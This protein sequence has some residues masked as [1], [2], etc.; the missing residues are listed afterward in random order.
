MTTILSSTM[1]KKTFTS[2]KVMLSIT[3]GIFFLLVFATVVSAHGYVESPASRAYLCKQNL[4]TNCGQV[5]Y[6]PQSVEGKGNFPVGGPEDGKITGGGIFAQLYDQTTDRWTKLDMETGSQTFT[7]TLTAP[8]ATKE[9]KYYIT[10]QDW[11]PNTPIKRSDLELFCSYSDNG[12]VPEKTVSHNCSVPVDHTGYHV[13]LG[14]WEIADT[15]NAF[16]QA[17]D[18]NLRKPGSEAGPVIDTEAP[19]IPTNVKA[20][21]VTRESLVLNWNPSK[22]NVAVTNYDIYQN[23]VKIASV[24][25]TSISY[26]VSGLNPGTA[27]TYKLKAIDAAGNSSA[28][29]TEITVR[30][31]S[32]TVPDTTAPTAPSHL[33]AHTIA[34]TSVTLMWS[35]ST[36]NVAV[37]AYDIYQGTTRI[38]TVSGGVTSYAVTGLKS[39]TAYTFSVKA[40]DAA[41]NISVASNAIVVTTL[42]EIQPPV[43]EDTPKAWTINTA[44]QIGDRVIYKGIIYTCRQSHKSLYTWTPAEVLALWLPE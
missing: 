38:A 24:P 41:G 31:T 33:H 17:I 15:G 42:E 27:Y 23:G 25:G 14:V 39:S 22:D 20:S 3:I 19:T 30:T 26:L 11:N 29:S 1:S 36:D 2:F 8:H 12:K 37:T 40:R 6:E 7:W 43:S 10:K 9:W 13:I 5:Q 35:N 4:N 44:Y 34:A 21:N 28:F 32:Q 18:V 16:Y